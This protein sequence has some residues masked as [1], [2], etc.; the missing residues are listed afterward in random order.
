MEATAGSPANEWHE[1]EEAIDSDGNLFSDVN[2]N[3]SVDIYGVVVESVSVAKK[4]F[5]GEIAYGDQKVVIASERFMIDAISKSGSMVTVLFNAL[6][7]PPGET[8]YGR[9]KCQAAGATA[10][11][12]LLY[13]FA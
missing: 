12:S 9:L 3:R 1:W 6:R 10:D 11:I 2:A 13:N 7:L 4:M 5:M 8:L